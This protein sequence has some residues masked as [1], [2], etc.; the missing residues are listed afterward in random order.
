MPSIVL[1]ICATCAPLDSGASIPSDMPAASDSSDMLSSPIGDG[2]LSVLVS[3]LS[4][5]S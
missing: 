1:E 4:V 2:I 3:P 5:L